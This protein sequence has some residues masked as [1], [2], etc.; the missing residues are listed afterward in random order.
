MA[1]P[2]TLRKVPTH[3]P[4]AATPRA[5]A[6]SEPQMVTVKAIVDTLTATNGETYESPRVVYDMAD[7][8]IPHDVFV[9]T[10]LTASLVLAIK[11]GD[12]EEA[13]EGTGDTTR[14]KGGMPAEFGGRLTEEV[15]Q[16]RQER[17]ERAE[18]LRNER[19]GGERQE[20]QD[21]APTRQ[22]EG[23]R[24]DSSQDRGPERRQE[25]QQSRG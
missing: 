13:D 25:E 23:G 10:P 18:Q 9:T 22:R 16:E 19:Q 15:Q 11:A 20:P 3:N 14:V 2:N 12:I 5:M 17:R 21:A 24:P 1:D 4:R 6:Q 8:P 7:N